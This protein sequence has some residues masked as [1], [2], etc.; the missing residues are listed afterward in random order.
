MPANGSEDDFMSNM[1]NTL[2]LFNA[3]D[4]VS[5]RQSGVIC[6]VAVAA[7]SLSIFGAQCLL[8]SSI[9]VNYRRHSCLSHNANT[10]LLAYLPMTIAK[11]YEHYD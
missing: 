7:D 2:P 5:D 10:L 1:S 4:P 6:V 11:D 3:A 9:T 8:D